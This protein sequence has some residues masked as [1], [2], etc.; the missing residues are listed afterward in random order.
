MSDIEEKVT[1]EFPISIT[2][3]EIERDFFKHLRKK[4][5][6]DISYGFISEED[7]LRG[8]I[9]S[10]NAPIIILRFKAHSKSI[11]L[12]IP[13]YGDIEREEQLRLVTELRQ[14]TQNYFSQR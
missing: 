13:E 14:K 11:E 8:A 12:E 3:E 9:T 1:I 7:S 2:K 6:C 4:I 10:S 5:P